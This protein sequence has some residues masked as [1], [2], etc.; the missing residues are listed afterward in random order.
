MSNHPSASIWTRSVLIGALVA[1]HGVANAGAQS[2]SAEQ[3][4]A[5]AEE[6]KVT[7]IDIRRP[8]EWRSTGVGQ[9]VERIGMLH[10]GGVR[11]FAREVLGAVDGDLDAPIALICRTG[12]RTARMQAVMAELGFTNVYD[13]REGMLGSRFG[14]GW[15]A[16]GL[17]VE[18]CT[19][20]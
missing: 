17:P 7:I 5:L 18:P 1:L 16:R 15:I 11:G 8:E 20:C 19:S 3:A 12:N 10:P 13:I 4:F 2:L 14:P 6:G 9:G